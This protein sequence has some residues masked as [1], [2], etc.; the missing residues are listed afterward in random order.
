MMSRRHFVNAAV[1]ALVVASVPGLQSQPNPASTPVPGL[2]D[3]TPQGVLVG[4]VVDQWQMQDSRWRQLILNN[5]N[6]VTLGKLKWSYVRPSYAIYD[7]RETDWMVSFCREKGVSMHG[8]NLCW[9]ANNPAWLGQ[10]LTRNN[11][12]GI[13]RSHI[14]TIVKRYAGKIGSWDVVNEP[15]ATWMGRSDGLYMGSWLDAIGPEY[16]DIAFH[17]TA[18]ADAAALRVLNIAHVEQGGRGSDDA[19]IAT[20]RL[21]EALLKRGVPIQAIGFESHLA[22]N[23]SSQ[24]TA[25]RSVF[26]NELRQFGLQ[27]LLTEIDVDDTHLPTDIAQRDAAVGKCYSDY[28]TSILQE[29]KPHRIIFFS[30]SDQNNWYDAAHSIAFNRNDGVHHRPGV[31]DDILAPKRFYAAIASALRSY[32]A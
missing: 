24:S 27:I 13:L 1:G 32:P 19:R 6:L 29:A 5:F 30:P 4:A 28:L 21:V 16:I 20:L 7:F 23:Y 8:H 14:Q 26:V 31:F 25:S 9:N 2:K 17:A 3:L 10:T 18:E 22:G 12:T 15:V 11:A